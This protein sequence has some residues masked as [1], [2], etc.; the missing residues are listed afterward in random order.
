[1]EDLELE[2]ANNIKDKLN[3]KV[4]CIRIGGCLEALSTSA[5]RLQ[6]AVAAFGEMGVYG[7]VSLG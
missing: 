4:N 2:N 3:G 1:M 7:A 5:S 6:A